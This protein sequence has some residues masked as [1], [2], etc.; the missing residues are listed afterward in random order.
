VRVWSKV[1]TVPSVSDSIREKHFLD[2]IEKQTHVYVIYMLPDISEE[3]PGPCLYIFTCYESIDKSTSLFKTT[4]IQ[5]ATKTIRK[6]KAFFISRRSRQWER[7]IVHRCCP[8]VRLS[9]R[10][11]VAKM[12]KTRF[13]QKLSNLEPWSLL[14]TCRKSYMGFSKNPLLDP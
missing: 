8:S 2:A 6:R 13:S 11:S 14:T 9:V 10:L 1:Q 12:Q 4:R 7:L 5:Y 3:L